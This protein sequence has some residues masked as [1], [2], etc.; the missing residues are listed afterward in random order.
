VPQTKGILRANIEE[1]KV[2]YNASA[3]KFTTPRVAYVVLFD[4]K[5]SFFYF[6]KRSSILQRWRCT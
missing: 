3:V 4:N 2:M 6:E 1:Y 5:K